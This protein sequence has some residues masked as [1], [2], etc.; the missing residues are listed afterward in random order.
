MPFHI[1]GQSVV[2]ESCM[3]QIKPGTKIPNKLKAKPEE[4]T[5][6]KPDSKTKKTAEVHSEE[7][8]APGQM[9][10]EEYQKLLEEYSDLILS[11]SPKTK[12]DEPNGNAPASGKTSDDYLREMET[13]ECEDSEN[14]NLEATHANKY[15]I[16]EKYRDRNLFKGRKKPKRE[17][18][19]EAP[20]VADTTEW[21]TYFTTPRSVDEIREKIFF[22]FDNVCFSYLCSWQQLPEEFIPELMA[23]ST[24]LL[25]A[26][27]YKTY[28][29][30]LVKAV[31]VFEQIEPG[32][33]DFDKLP[34]DHSL[35]KNSQYY[36]LT[37][38]LDWSALGQYQK[39]SPEFR[40]KYSSLLKEKPQPAAYFAAK[41]RKSR[42]E[43]SKRD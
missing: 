8:S 31:H 4:K 17:W 37:D 22:D 13:E 34:T 12:I 5:K 16:P 20:K 23:L 40:K 11:P 26:D 39:L 10:D 27:N 19:Y 41:M 21:A 29:D 24:G 9:S 32:D 33:I 25:N 14:S 43:S 38:R 30:E 1:E 42:R 28:K 3:G 6:A 2:K 35:P 36:Q 18:M 7:K 15:S